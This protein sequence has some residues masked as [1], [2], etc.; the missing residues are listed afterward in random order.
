MPSSRDK[1]KRSRSWPVFGLLACAVVLTLVFD[2][3]GWLDYVEHKAFDGLFF[4][5]HTMLPAE[6]RPA[7]PVSLI[8]LDDRTFEDEAF[9]LPLILWHKHFLRVL[10][11][12]ADGGAR[13]VLLDFLLP[14]TRFQDLEPEFSQTWLKALV[15]A[16]S[17]G[18]PVVTGV[19]QTAD[20][21]FAPDSRYLQIVGPEYTGLF[22]LTVDSDDFVRRQRLV[23]RTAGDSSRELSSVSYLAARVFRPGLDVDRDVLVIDYDPGPEPFARHSFVDVFRRAEAGDTAFFKERFGGRIVLIGQTD[24]LTQDRHPTPLYHFFS[25]GD[26]RMPGVEILAH[27]VNT[28][29]AGR[30]FSQADLPGRLA[31]Y[32]LLSLLAGAGPI[33]VSHRLAFFA[34]VPLLL[35]WLALGLFAFSEYRLL[36]V[37]GGLMSVITSGGASLAWRHWVMD[38]E[39]RG[40]RNAFSRYV[41]PAVAER[42]MADPEA[43][44]LAGSRRVM[45][46]FFSDL[47]GFTAISERFADRP[48]ALVALLNRYL[49]RMTEVIMGR[50]GVVDKFEGDAVMAFWGAPLTR[51]DHALQACLAALDQQ[52]RLEELNRELNAD[53]L[54]E[55][56]ARMGINTGEMI[57]GNVGSDVRL[58]YTVMGDAVNLASR[59]EGANKVFGTRILISESTWTQVRGRIEGRNLGRIAVKGRQTALRIYEVMAPAGAMS[60]DRAKVRQAFE[61]GLARYEAGDLAGAREA[62]GRALEADPDDGPARAYLDRC[63]DIGGGP[64]SDDWDGVWR[65]ESK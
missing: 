30:F 45:T 10:A 24:S 64:L 41:S 25:S 62:F 65:L 51:E 22:N 27:I 38:R 2:L 56:T 35:L 31:L 63:L 47:A 7:S 19:I 17:R 12:L 59:L 42:A 61:D 43:L 6:T 20:R 5:R 57:V 55:L 39:K 11:A 21:L 36:P 53:G 9:R 3:N 48:E 58:E 50:D 18:T 29:L 52:A 8:G 13:V 34:P 15:Y 40:L 23:F 26:R 1:T 49:K 44:S 46:V 14:R 54:P 4:V 60:T 16:R 33:F 37:A 32:V 28:L